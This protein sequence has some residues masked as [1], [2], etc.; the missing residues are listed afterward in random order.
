MTFLIT[1]Q[2]Q[3]TA[4]SCFSTCIAMIRCEPANWTVSQIHDWYFNEQASIREVL[5]KLEIPFQSFDTADNHS[6]KGNGVYLVGV[7][8]L[9]HVG[10][11]HQILCETFDGMFIVRDPCAGLEGSKHYVATLSGDDREVKLYG[12]F[13]DAFIP[14]TYIEQRYSFKLQNKGAI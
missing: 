9:N 14:R 5:E 4:N 12:Y 8:S 1:P 2:M 3:P 6:F 11:M 7:P 10:G 13:I